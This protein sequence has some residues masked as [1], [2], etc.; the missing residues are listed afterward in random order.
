MNWKDYEV[1]VFS[2]LKDD[3]PRSEVTLNAKIKGL[4]SKTIRQID[5]L[6]EE[7]VAGNRIRIIFEAKYFNR[8]IDVKAVESCLGM[9][10]DV[11]A[12]KAIMVSAK[13]FSEA[14]YNR[15]F[16]GPSNIE[17]DILNF[18]QLK[19]FQ[20]ECALPYAG[21]FGA[22]ISAPFGW[23]V[24]GKQYQPFT[25]T[26]YRRGLNLEEAIEN[27]EFMYI[28]YYGLECCDTTLD[29]VLESH[30]RELLAADNN[31]NIEWLAT[32]KR[33]DAKVLLCMATSAGCSV[34]ECTGFIVFQNYIFMCV[35]ITPENRKKQNIRK[36]ENVLVSTI[37]MEIT[38]KKR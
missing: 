10:E 14:A 9:L 19:E 21:K 36:L 20:G 29:Q 31:T 32:I 6:I 38:H 5:V 8:K 30:R 37:P 11:E 17:L 35:L 23:I 15:A 34:I 27:K 12:N 2:R 1:E 22:L 7:Y 4:Y 18:D 26:L 28:N 24:D 3:Y 25:A 13:G 16:Y 33:D